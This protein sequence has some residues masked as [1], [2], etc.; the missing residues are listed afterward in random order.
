VAKTLPFVKSNMWNRH[1]ANSPLPPLIRVKLN[2]LTC[3]GCRNMF[4][5]KSVLLE[6]MR[7]CK[8]YSELYYKEL[9]SS[10]GYG[11]DREIKTSIRSDQVESSGPSSSAY[12]SPV[13]GILGILGNACGD[14]G[15]TASLGIFTDSSNP[16]YD[17]AGSSPYESQTYGTPDIYDRSLLRP[18]TRSSPYQMSDPPV[19]PF[20]DSFNT[21]IESSVLSG[22]SASNPGADAFPTLNATER[23]PYSDPYSTLNYPGSYS[24]DRQFRPYR[25]GFNDPDER[26]R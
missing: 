25:E 16:F 13:P 9:C 22:S 10:F 12:Q 11:H 17:V 14:V 6:H 24:H 1:R 15:P 3:Q 2:E 8:Q 5:S 4:R 7:A 18:D 23:A 20:G 26:R 19:A 21:R